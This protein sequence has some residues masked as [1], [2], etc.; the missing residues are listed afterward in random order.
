MRQPLQQDAARSGGLARGR[1][2]TK[3][4]RGQADKS[5]ENSGEMAVA[6][7]A[8]SEGNRGQILIGFQKEIDGSPE[9]GVEKVTVQRHAHLLTKHSS[10]MERRAVYVI[11]EGRK[12]PSFSRISQEGDSRRFHLLLYPGPS[13]ADG[14]MRLA[15]LSPGTL[16]NMV[17]QRNAGLLDFERVRESSFETAPQQVTRGNGRR[18]EQGVGP[19]FAQKASGAGGG[20][21]LL[22]RGLRKLEDQA[23]VF[24]TDRVADPVSAAR[25]KQ[26]GDVGFGQNAVSG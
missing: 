15:R 23:I 11:G 14:K 4:P 1:G 24:I 7:K 20:E 8:E 5:P 10:Q 17:Q 12:C 6:R 16:Q 25:S 3:F 9:S 2:T 19:D 13:A 21:N 18:R 26:K 22:K